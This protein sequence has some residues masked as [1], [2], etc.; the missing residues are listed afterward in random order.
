[1]TMKGNAALT[2]VAAG[3]ALWLSARH[4]SSDRISRALAIAIV[5]FALVTLSEYVFGWDAHIDEA[6]FKD[7]PSAGR[8]W[9]PGR[10]ALGTATC[11]LLF[12]LS[13]LPSPTGRGG[14]LGEAFALVMG[15][16]SAIAL[17]GYLYGAAPLLGSAPY[18]AMAVL[19]AFM[20]FTLAAG[21]LA[22]HAREDTTIAVMLNDTL[23]AASARRL[24]PV[25]IATPVLAGWLCL[26]GE[27]AGLY[28]HEFGAAVLIV[29]TITILSVVIWR[30]SKSLI[31]LEAAH[32]DAQ[33]ALHDLTISARALELFREL[34]ES[35]PD[36]MVIVDTHGRIRLANAQTESLFGYRREE[37]LGQP[38]EM[39]VPDRFTASHPRYRASY[40]SAPHVRAMGSGL[41]LFALRK[42]G[43]EFP[44]EISLSP[45]QTNDGTLVSS[46]IRDITGRKRLEL[47]LQQASRLKSEFLTNM[48][49]ELRTPLNAI[50]GFTNLLHKET[51]GPVSPEQREYLGDVL[52]SARHLLQLINDVLDLAKVESGTMEIRA[53]TVDLPTLIGE[54]QLVL[55]GLASMKRLRI[56]AHVDPDVATVVVDPSRV[57]QM[58]YNYLSNA[59][60]FTSDGGEIHVRARAE[61]DHEFRLEVEDTGVGVASEDIGRLFVEFQQVVSGSETTPQGTGLGLALTKRL[62]EAHGG[63]VAVRSMPGRGSTFA[64]VLPRAAETVGS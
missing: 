20:L 24:L 31:G 56:D 46:A 3:I 59:I 45:L 58:L 47:Q 23:G 54:V 25:A 36:A 60:K 42:D 35:A 2:F 4:G 37:L 33:H 40:F 28:G 39:L 11:F 48:S 53:E 22:R 57:K 43:T 13:L 62:A 9:P 61:G 34:L 15:L 63:S 49:H 17:V 64:V 27:R 10:L 21:S 14:R 6:L 5:L 18:S 38:V 55:R 26:L 16:Q 29:T 1:M 19:T 7:D 51:A 41:D 52:N 44:I 32:G 50:I 12:G 8:P 30:N